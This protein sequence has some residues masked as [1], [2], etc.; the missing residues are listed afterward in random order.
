MFKK[1]LILFLLLTVTHFIS[2]QKVGLVLSGGGAKG[3]VHIGI[4]KALEE[5]AIPIDYVAGTSIGA[6]VGS[7]YA[8]GYSP[9]EMLE[10][11]M[12]DDFYYWQ[13]GK[14]EEDYQFYFRKP[15]SN[16]SFIQ[17]N[18]S[19]KDS[20]DITESLIPNSLINPIQMNQAFLELYTQANTQ[21][22]GNFNNLFVP[23]L[24]VASDIYNKKP[25]IFRQ[26][27]LGDA[28]RASMTFPLFFK[29][30]VKDSIPL[31]D[32]GIYD[33]FPITPMREA[34]HPDFIIGSSV[35]GS[36]SKSPAE[37]KLYDQVENMIMQR[38]DYTVAP[39][40][41]IMMRFNLEDV[42]LLD[43]NKAKDL[44]QIGYERTIQMIDSIQLRTPRRVP[45]S[46]V[47]ARRTAYKE[48]LPPL[49]FN[50]IYISGATSA[51]KVY[52]ENQ[53]QKNKEDNFTF[54]DFKRTYFLLLSNSK[55]EEIFPHAEYDPESRTF[56]LFLDI[57]MSDDMMVSFGGNISSM[58]ANQVFLGL[59]YQSLSSLSSNLNLDMQLGNAFTGV[60]MQGRVEMP[61]KIPF[62]VSAIFSYNTRQFYESEKLFIDT[63]LSTFSNQ[64]ET[65]GKLAMG[66]PFQSKAKVDIMAGY[67]ELEDRY[68]QNHTGSFIDIEFDK[69]IYRLFN[70]GLYYKKNSFNAKQFPITGQNHHVYGQYI[71][72]EEI[73]V[74][75]QKSY[76]TTKR[77]AYLQL[78]A[79]LTNFNVINSKFNLGYMLEG[80]V[81]SKNLWSNYTASMLQAPGFTPTPHS[82]LVYNEAFHAN[83]YVAGGIIPIIKLNSTFHI[84]GDFY[85]FLPLYQ[86]K[87]GENNTA[88]YGNLFSN[89][90]YSGEI[91]IV[92]QFQ[93]MNVSL[94]ANHYSYPKNNWNFGLNIG[95]LIFGHKFIQ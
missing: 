36:N 15:P 55:I 62:D 57:R 43:F 30:L 77:Q 89:P 65:F 61:Y 19:L 31:W 35:A 58:N 2:S 85:G 18:I 72:G 88:Y 95:Y 7:L 24:C 90:A 22:N 70:L 76:R 40:E 39:E 60:T 11:I 29:P 53:I 84:R 42:S 91:S 52:I 33:N 8:M 71:S 78:S 10:L 69:S 13:T 64:R 56:D 26:G 37:Q 38:T 75:A 54:Q 4:I 51:Q 47:N 28:V 25:L 87:K 27:N 34:W 94:Y 80:V 66:L 63:D 6:V 92:A 23:F 49:V 59:G 9:E 68:Y 50:N 46:E 83:Q 16:P 67:G 3:A 20:I 5:N 48:S 74:E 82:M 86:I 79:N 32:G 1:A 73:F 41:G 93:F 44:Y 14:V 45:L 12:S 81:S 21:S 17:F